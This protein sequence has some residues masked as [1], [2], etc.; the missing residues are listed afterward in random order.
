LFE[1]NIS[2]PDVVFRFPEPFP[3]FEQ[4]TSA[5]RS[6]SIALFLLLR[7]VRLALGQYGGVATRPNASILYDPRNVLALDAPGYALPDESN[8]APYGHRNDSFVCK[9]VTA[10]IIVRLDNN[11]FNKAVVR[12]SVMLSGCNS[13]FCNNKHI[14]TKDRDKKVPETCRR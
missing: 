12:H 1:R 11:R 10:L 13:G 6:V 8:G 2:A 4:T 14:I 9:A 7:R 3:G 5:G